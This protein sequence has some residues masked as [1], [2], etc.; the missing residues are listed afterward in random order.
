MR[1]VFDVL[2]RPL[3]TEKST[4]LKD[5]DNQVVFETAKW[6]SKYEIKSAVKSLFGVDVMSVQ[7]MNCRGKQKRIGKIVGKKRN[8]KKAVIKF[9]SGAD[10]DTLGVMTPVV[11]DESGGAKE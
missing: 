7:T 3:V 4:S 11:P 6:A 10:V 1:T 9:K 2:R 8:W 5:N